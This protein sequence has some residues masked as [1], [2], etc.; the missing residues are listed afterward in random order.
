MQDFDMFTLF[1][2]A[3]LEEMSCEAQAHLSKHDHDT[4][5]LLVE[6][7]QRYV[8]AH[9]DE[10]PAANVLPLSHIS[11]PANLSSS[12]HC[13]MGNRS[14]GR[15]Q[16][17]AVNGALQQYRKHFVLLSPFVAISGDHAGAAHQKSVT[18]A[19]TGCMTRA[20]EQYWQHTSV[21]TLLPTGLMLF[22][23]TSPM[24]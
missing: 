6:C 14:L 17:A 7:L 16:S 18:S 12:G 23:L 2:R 21:I 15:G 24:C 5:R 1:F 22:F 11:L 8:V 20:D 13:S 4:T 3:M 19:C 10:L 9:V